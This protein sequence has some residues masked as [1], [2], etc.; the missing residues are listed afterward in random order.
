MMHLVQFDMVR[1][2]PPQRIVQVAANFISRQ[3]G[4]AFIR[5]YCRIAHGP[6]YLRSQHYL[7]SP[8]AAL[9]EP[10]PDDLLGPA[11]MLNSTVDV[12]RIKEID[13][14]I[15]RRVHDLKRFL[16]IRRRT[17]IHRPQTQTAHLQAGSSQTGVLHVNNLLNDLVG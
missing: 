11:A 1:A 3:A 7:L 6:V 13:A 14:G 16:L 5:V 10:A 8:A 2:E 12:G 9:R 17:K 4:S 15:D